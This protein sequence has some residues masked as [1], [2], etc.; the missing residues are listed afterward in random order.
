VQQPR[1]K[2]LGRLASLD[3]LRG[4]VMI[5]M[6]LD[7]VRDFFHSGA[8]LFAPE[9]L[10][11]TT[12]A[13]FFTRWIT[14]FCAPVFAFAAGVGAFFWLSRSRTAE[15]LTG[16]LLKRGLWL[17]LLDLTAVRFAM[18]FSLTSGPVILSVLWS[19]GWSMVLLAF[20]ARLPVHLTGAFSLAIIALH[21][22]TDRIPASTFGSAAWLWSVLHQTTALPIG[23]T[24][25]LTAYPLLPWIAVMAAGFY[26]GRVMPAAAGPRG[27]W[28]LRLG[29]CLTL[30]FV[31]LRGINVYGDPRPWSPQG[32][33]L[34]TALAFL[35]TTKYPPSLQFLLMTLG[36]ALLIWGAFERLSWRSPRNPLLVFGRVPL[37]YFLLHLFVIRAL[38]YPFTLASYGEVSFLSNPL[39]SLGGSIAD[40][41]PG[42]GYS[43]PIVYLVWLL[44]ELLMYPACLWFAALKNRRR[45]WWLNYF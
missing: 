24:V 30:G 34:M 14:H 33:P 26:L 6:A 27:R 35:R 44:V 41:P 37:F 45:D 32:S 40:Y 39:P 5:I 22:L 10:A 15:Q 36:P 4:L 38:T 1:L 12:P 28:L 19:L 31:L 8:M 9:D 23:G 7:H 42:Y 18:F 29:I 11:R 20:L 2:A 16:F 3:A 17:V 25:V 43:L 21:N 13:L